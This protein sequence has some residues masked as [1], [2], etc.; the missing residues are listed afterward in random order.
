MGGAGAFIIKN[1]FLQAVFCI[2]Q[3]EIHSIKATISTINSIFIHSY[4]EKQSLSERLPS[5]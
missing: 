5:L 4:P 3:S 2:Q 1:R